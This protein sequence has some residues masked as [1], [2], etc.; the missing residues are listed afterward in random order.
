MLATQSCATLCD[1]M[2]C[3]PPGSSVHGVLQARILERLPFSP[4]TSFQPGDR[5][6]VSHV[7]CTGRRVLYHC[8]GWEAHSV[9]A[10]PGSTWES[11]SR[12]EEGKHDSYSTPKEG[13]GTVPG[14]FTSA[15]CGCCE[16]CY[17]HVC[18]AM[19]IPA[20]SMPSSYPLA[21]PK[22]KPMRPGLLR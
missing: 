21:P 16:L 22:L 10:V 7:S 3:S 4:Q 5:T 1:P 9:V 6:P 8:A 20:I 2:D 18:V 15:H 17:F 11:S 19:R 13:R 12:D 14:S